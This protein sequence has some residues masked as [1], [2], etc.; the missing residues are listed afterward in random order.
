MEIINMNVKITTIIIS[1][2]M[3]SLPW[4]PLISGQLDEMSKKNK[5]P[6]TRNWGVGGSNDTGWIDFAAEGADQTNGTLAYGDLF[7]DF[8]PGAIID[9]LT[10]EVSVNG[11]DGY[12]INQPQLS[13]INTQTE[14]FDWSGLGDLGRQEVF[15]NNPPNVQ[16]G[17]LDA[18]LSP[19][20]LTDAYWNLPAGITITDLIIEA[21]RPVDPLVSF[22]PLDIKIYDVAVN[23]MDGS[24][25]VLVDD[26]MLR[27]DNNSHKTIIDI[28]FGISGR[29]LSID[30]K[31]NH[32]IIGTSDGST[33]AMDLSSSEPI[34]T[35]PVDVNAT[36]DDPIISTLIDDYNILWAVSECN[37]N[38]LEPGKGVTWISRGICKD[39]DTVIS[40]NE[41]IIHNNSIYL[42]TDDTGIFQINYTFDSAGLI[43][44]DIEFPIFDSSNFLSSDSVSDLELINDILYI[45]TSNSGIDRFNVNSKSWLPPW[46]SNNWLSSNSIHGMAASS[47][48]LHIFAGSSIHVYDTD[49]MIERSTLLISDMNLSDSGHSINTW[50]GLDLPRSPNSDMVLIGDASGKLV[51]IVGEDIEDS[52][53]LATSPESGENAQVT[54]FIEDGNQGE[55]WIGGSQIIDRFDKKDKL[56]KEAIDIQELLNNNG[57]LEP[58]FNINEITTILQDSDGR[59]WIGTNSGLFELDIDGNLIAI[60][61]TFSSSDFVIN[62][63]YISSVAHDSNTNMLIVGHRGDGISLINTTSNTVAASLT[64]ADGLDSDFIVEVVTRF[65]IAYIATQDAGVMRID[66]NGPT[67][68]GS[69]QSLGADNLDSTPV[70]IDGDII[71]LGLPGFGLLLIDRI[72]GEI[73][74]LWTE[75]DTNSI[76]DNDI[77]S[78]SID[79]YGGLLVGSDTDR[80]NN[81]WNRGDCGELARW[82]GSQW[83]LLPTEIPGGNN[84]PYAFYDITSDANGIYAGTNRGACMWYW[85]TASEPDITLNEC[86]NEQ[87]GTDDDLSVPSRY[88]LAVSKIGVDT[89]Y[90]GTTEGAAVINTANGTIMDV[91]TAGDETERAR[92]L[93]IADVVYIGFENTGI[94]RYNMSSFTWMAPWDGSQGFIEDDDVT[95]IIPGIQYGTM[96]VGGDFGITLID[97]LNNSVLIDWERGDNENGPT[98]PNIAPSDMIIIDNVMYFSPQRAQSWTERDEVYRINLANNSSL[99]SLDAGDQLGLNAEGVIH[100]INHVGNEL[101]ISVRGTGWWGQPG[102]SGTVVRWNITSNSWSGSLD[103][104]GDVERVNARY[105]G[106]CFPITDSCELWVSY[107]ENIIRRFSAGNMTLLNQWEN[108]NGRI[109]GMVEFNNE[110]LFA[111]EVGILR[112]SPINETWLE[113]WVPGNGLPS[114]SE[115]DFYSMAVSGNNLIASSGSYNDGKILAKNSNSTNWTTWDTNSGDIPRGYGAD[116]KYCDGIYHIAIG[117]Q[118]P[119]WQSGGGIA[120]FDTLDHD[121]D[122]VSNE[123]ISPLTTDNSQISDDDP[124]ALACDNSN[125]IL[126]I[127]FDNEG[128]G[129]DRFSYVSNNFLDP[130]TNEANGISEGAVFPGGMLYDNSNNLLLIAHFGSESGISRIITSGNTAGNGIIIDQGMDACSIVKSPSSGSQVYAIGRSGQTSGVNRVDRL[131]NTGLIQGGFDELVGLPGGSIQ[132]MISNSTHVWVTHS[133]YFDS[134]WGSTIL[135]GEIL[136]N[137]SVNWQYGVRVLDDIINEMLLDGDNIWVSTV[138]DGLLYLNT[139]TKTLNQISSALTR[140][141]DGLYL[142]DDGMLYIGLMGY[143]S[144]SAGFQTFETTAQRWSHGSLI[145]GLPN[146]IVNDFVE[147]NDHIMVATNGGIGLWNTTI[148]GWDNPITTIDGLPSSHTEHLMVLPSPIQGNGAILLGGPIGLSILDQNLSYITMLDS[149]NGLIGD[150]VSGLIYAPATFREYVN[151]LDNSTQIIH[152]DAA[153]FISHNGQ[154]STRPGVAAWDLATDRLNGTYNIDMIPSNDVRSVTGDTWGIHIA[155]D[156]EPIVHWNGTM[157]RMES[158]MG[159]EEL[160]SW[161]AS[162]IISDGTHIVVISPVGV[163]II[164]SSGNHEH[165]YSKIIPGIVDADIH[166]GILSLITQNG[167]RL[168]SPIETL[169]E[170][171]NQYQKRASPL[172]IVFGDKTWDITD[173]THPGMDITLATINNTIN[174]TNNPNNEVEN[175]ELPLSNSAL[176]FI[177]PQSGAWVWAKSQNL[178][179][180][181]SWDLTEYNSGLE[182]TFQ[183]AIFNTPPGSTSSQLHIRLQSPSDGKLQVRI[184][185]DWN[186]LEAPT[187]ITNLTDRPNDGGGILEASWLPA[188]DSAWHAYRLYVWDSTDSPEWTPNTEDLDEFSKYERIIFWSDTSTVISEA[189]H[190]G[191]VKPLS[192][193]RQYRAAISIE[194]QDGSLGQPM[195]WEGNATPTDEIPEPPEWLSVSPLSGGVP[196]V[197]SAEWSA[198]AELD[199]YL[200]RI[201]AV[202]QEITSAIAL[203][204]SSDLSFASGN[205]T[206]L[207]LEANKPYWFAIVCVDEA[208]QSKPSNATIFGPV[209]TAG[210][211]ND[212]IPPAQITEVS[213]YDVPEDEGGRIEITWTSNMEADCSYYVIYILPAS[214]FQPPESVDGWPTAAYVPDCSS[215]SIIIDSIGDSTLENGLVYWIGVVAVDDWGNMATEP[216]NVVSTTPYSELDSISFSPPDKINGLMAWDHPQDDGSSIDVV[217]NRSTA[218]DFSHYTIWVS[219]YPLNDLTEIYQ[220]CLEIECN[221]ITINQRQ[222]EN[223]IQLEITIDNALYGNDID[224]LYSN[225]ILPS[226]PLY[227]A[228]TVHDISGNVH[229]SNLDDYIAL[230]TPIDNRGDVSPPDRLNAPI[231]TDRNPDSG[232]GMFVEFSQSSDSD[233]YEYWIYAVAGNPFTQVSNIDPALIVNR[234]SQ[235]IILLDSFSDGQSLGPSLPIWVAVVP[236]DSSGNAQF[237]GLSTSMITLVDESILDPGAHLPVV[238]GIQSY[239]DLAG[240]QVEIK[241]D[242]STDE[243]VISYSAY[244]SLTPFTDTREATLLMKN[245]TQGMISFNTFQNNVIDQSTIYW[246]AVVASDG[247][248]ERIGINPSEVTPWIDYTPEGGGLINNDAEMS[249]LDQLMEGNM[250]SL[251]AI[252]SSILIFIGAVLIIKPKDK[253]APEPWEMGTIEVELEDELTRKDENLELEIM[254]PTD[255]LI[256]DDSNKP[257][258]SHDENN[259]QP[260]NADISSE[261]E[262]ELLSS[263]E[264][265]DIMDELNQMADGMENDELNQMAEKLSKENIDTSFIDDVL[266]DQ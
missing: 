77:I 130:L 109:R 154:G 19:N 152:H 70:A 30:S 208:G 232:D 138:G 74:D 258:I 255:D 5:S 197:V 202:Q 17:I 218:N 79:F 90:V 103:T 14:I 23:P 22:S 28:E 73:S 32:L 241:W 98:L 96:W 97:T 61:S 171:P 247:E 27:L 122:G 170:M 219:E 72:T 116:I 142:E 265:I 196:G 226:I 118:G 63:N 108:N 131:D 91:W 52:I 216:V 123:W 193:D 236:V 157:M 64:T 126:Y 80:N 253:S 230:V 113:T 4:A 100:G 135:Q 246:V 121:G 149:N 181:G 180:T 141:M 166:D 87:G 6:T 248:F 163:D 175:G 227:V 101:W 191:M 54:A 204:N 243:K 82:D 124:R 251:I 11:S 2:L 221:L 162:Q 78:L 25:M 158:G 83:E 53:I 46:S 50:P 209:V 140:N 59:I 76:P 242:L 15:V 174:I 183:S 206:V 259:I 225:N 37:I 129:I 95:V 212:G 215:D 155:T 36:N 134:N 9:N 213:A 150:T 199:T 39:N 18:A 38:Y 146:N 56:W 168:F 266:E 62:G 188:Q 34:S 125:G 257:E 40:P 200:T 119:W 222:I 47:G 177:A 187:T 139:T 192:D 179:Y 12:W 228:V 169:Q 190:E 256:I 145:A 224:S 110:Y 58:A 249:W 1:C 220:H 75:D 182:T 20:S 244:Y 148:S 260:L 231:L 105:L 65:G 7:L 41:V 207:E 57:G 185:Y 44:T 173:S 68:L 33:L 117:F 238:S 147:Y 51:T 69:W 178:N 16:Q 127:G 26:D 99:E 89:L 84:D 21:L 245:I 29:S 111:S 172:K 48:W 112:W 263:V 194:Y 217:W 86:W 237:T 234:N 137:G 164:K 67:I 144:S 133:D 93:R 114:D 252:I 132:E 235:T 161:P 229:M 35:F 233:V 240:T 153:I 3:V 24:L 88:V 71:Y 128:N 102:D 262:S 104:L 184:T 264:N 120:R 210:G 159:A 45:S 250:N 31:N 151:P 160:L 198:C 43:F 115:E 254:T 203:T 223:S 10:F 42:A 239:W 189:N 13:L 66:L 60:G 49:A 261:V 55:I 156:S 85:P 167:L 205:T 165:V 81:C 92:I 201:W 136:E 195:T 106:E 107:G 186:R 211:L 214:G 94:A 143:D 8:A 176:T